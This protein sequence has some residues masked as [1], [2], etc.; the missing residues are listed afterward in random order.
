[1]HRRTLSLFV[2]SAGHWLRRQWIGPL[3]QCAQ[4]RCNFY[5]RHTVLVLIIFHHFPEQS[6]LGGIQRLGNTLLELAYTLVG[7]LFGS[8]QGHLLYGLTCGLFYGP[9]QTSLAIGGKQYCLPGATGAAGAT[10]SVNVGLCIVGNIVVDD[11]AYSFHIQAPGSHVG[12]H[13]D[14]Q[15]AL[16]QALNGLL[17]L[18]L[19]NVAVKRGGRVASRRQFIGQFR[20]Q[21]ACAHKNDHP[22]KI[23]YF[24]DAGQ[25]V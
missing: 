24:E 21:D 19:G 5:H 20:C 8:G 11:V 10:N 4:C 9:Q 1:M 14:I 12:G 15:F 22:V 13:Q 2:S 16:F 7:H 18:F 3:G 6:E 17:A 23:L 25:R